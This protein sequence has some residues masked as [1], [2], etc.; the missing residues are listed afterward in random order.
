[1][2]DLTLGR[3][4]RKQTEFESHQVADPPSMFLKTAPPTVLKFNDTPLD[5]VIEAKILLI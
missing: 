1:M 5:Y 2:V 4:P 3:G